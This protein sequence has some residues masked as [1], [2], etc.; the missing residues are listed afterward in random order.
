MKNYRGRNYPLQLSDTY[1]FLF[2][3][4]IFSAHATIKR[5]NHKW[6]IIRNY[7]PAE[8]FRIL[9]VRS[10][11]IHKSTLFSLFTQQLKRLNQKQQAKNRK[12]SYLFLPF[13]CD[14]FLFFFLLLRTFHRNISARK[15]LVHNYL[16]SARVMSP[17]NPG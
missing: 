6:P 1:L 12:L 5:L 3:C 4:C 8:S 9:Q 7:F 17:I 2:V 13:F 15:Q 10:L 14:L 11:L 16:A